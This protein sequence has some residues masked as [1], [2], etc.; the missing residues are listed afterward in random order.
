LE[1]KRCERKGPPRGGKGEETASNDRDKPIPPSRDAILRGSIVRPS[2]EALGQC[3]GTNEYAELKWLIKR[4]GLLDKQPAYYTYKIL[5]TSGMLALSLALVLLTD[6]LWLQLLNAAYLAF[7]FTQIAFIGHDLGHRQIF[8]ADRKSAL[9]GLVVGNLIL[10]LSR[11]WWVDKH[12]RHHA[13]PNHDELDPD[14]DFPI[15]AF[16]EEQARSKR[17]FARF[18]VKYQ[19][20]LF[21]PLLMLEAFNMRIHSI[22][23]LIQKK[24]KYL[25]A[26]ALLLTVHFALYLGLL[27]YLLGL[28]SALLFVIIHQALFGVYLGSVFAPNHKG[29]PVLDK[30][31]K[32]D[33]LRRQVLTSRNL[34]AHPLTDFLFGPLG[35]Q[36]EHHLFPTMP[37]NNQRKAE[38]I[39]KAFCREKSIA[40]HETSVLRSYR[41]ILQH[42]H[43]VTVPLRTD[44]M[45][46]VK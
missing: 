30:D 17:G 15:L 42:L 34:K 4:Q 13:N 22:N 37:R 3:I 45:S 41:E 9:L 35:C 5:L 1:G 26:E 16:S 19:A 36:I 8:H 11:G 40:Y 20:Y 44:E 43:Q 25:L 46:E 39:V 7:I 33:F 23:F 18:V 21:F 14:I 28:W 12:N 6:T 2:L 27:F 32:M 31:T 24:G 29:M 38:K 10:G